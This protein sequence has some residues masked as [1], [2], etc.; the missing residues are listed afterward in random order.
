METSNQTH[1]VETPKRVTDNLLYALTDQIL[2]SI[3]PEEIK[4]RRA[5]QAAHQRKVEQSTTF[6]KDVGIFTDFVPDSIN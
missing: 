5:I 4:K 6:R 2:K 3:S 1:L